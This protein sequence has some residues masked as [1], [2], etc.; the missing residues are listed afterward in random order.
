M[1]LF[2][3]LLTIKLVY[4][5]KLEISTYNT[6]NFYSLE[7]WQLRCIATWGRP[8]SQQLFWT[9]FGQI[10]TTHLQKLPFRAFGQSCDIAIKFN[11]ADFLKENNNLAIRRRFQKFLLYKSKICPISISG[12]FDLMILKCITCCSSH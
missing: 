12:L 9:V 11:Y 8:T 6:A 3:H 1:L 10:C 7:G 4:W 2:T 5:Q